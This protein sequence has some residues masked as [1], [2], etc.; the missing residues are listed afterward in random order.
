L[1]VFAGIPPF[2]SYRAVNVPW[3]G[4]YSA[5]ETL[6]AVHKVEKYVSHYFQVAKESISEVFLACILSTNLL[7]SCNLNCRFEAL[8]EMNSPIGGN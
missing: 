2:L 3:V 8:L 1:K 5:L 6:S 7:V 4:R